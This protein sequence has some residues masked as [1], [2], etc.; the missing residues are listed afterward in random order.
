[1]QHVSHEHHIVPTA[2]YIKTF[3]ALSI[4]ML[5][6]ILAAKVDFPGGVIVNNVIAMAIASVKAFLVIW[7]FMGIK[8]ATKLTRLW[9]AAGFITFSLM[10]LILGDYAFRYDEVVPSWTGRPES[11]LPRV[12]DGRKNSV[13]PDKVDINFR[14]R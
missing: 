11:S 14:P 12:I 6:T 1:M 10:F 7:I 5:V 4:L 13:Q 2:T 3:F 8:W 9:T